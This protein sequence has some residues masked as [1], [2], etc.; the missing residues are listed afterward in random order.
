LGSECFPKLEVLQDY[1]LDIN[2]A[3]EVNFQTVY[4]PIYE[5]LPIRCS[6]HFPLFS[7]FLRLCFYALISDG[8]RLILTGEIGRNRC[9]SPSFE[10]SSST[11][12]FAKPHSCRISIFGDHSLPDLLIK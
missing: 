9:C 7:A 6:F 10:N 8:F 4:L 1:A 2:V 5:I 12:V 11:V 3:Y